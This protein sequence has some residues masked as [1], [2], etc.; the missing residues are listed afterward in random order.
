MQP[1]GLLQVPQASDALGDNS[2]YIGP[3]YISNIALLQGRGILLTYQGGLGFTIE[4]FGPRSWPGGFLNSTRPVR[5][6][7]LRGQLGQC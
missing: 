5:F 2:D 1:C 7:A 4:G 3:S 6:S